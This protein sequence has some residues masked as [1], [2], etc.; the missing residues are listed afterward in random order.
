[1]TS[2]RPTA[3]AAGTL[4]LGDHLTINRLGFG[5]M[6]LTGP[7]N[8]GP[9]RDP[10]QAIAVLRRAVELGVTFIDTADSYGPFIA[11]ELIRTALHPYPADLVVATKAG[12]LR[13]RPDRTNTP[14][15]ASW[16]PLGKPEYLRQQVEM[17][18]RRLGT[19]C[20]QLFQLHR[21]DPDYPLA[22]QVGELADLKAEGKI[23]LIGLSEVSVD[24][25]EEALQ[26]TPIASVQNLYNLTARDAE[27]LVNVCT[28]LGIAFIPW[29]PLGA[30]PLAASD[31]PLRKIAAA[32]HASSSQLALA[33]L[34]ARSPIM[35]PIPGTS[36][37]EHLDENIAAAAVTLTDDDLKALSAL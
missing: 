35:L 8:W 18:L 16:T 20:I 23:G 1:M 29:F 14:S 9:P 33:W 21:I 31:G 3:A 15:P 19:E 22:D 24:Q 17:S 11:E 25:L 10:H 30:G 34:L 5:T 26:I 7:G 4:K 32:H 6:R 13:T 37:L 36:S 2:D 28:Q 12:F 27:P